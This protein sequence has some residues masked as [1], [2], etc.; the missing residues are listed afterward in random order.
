MLT[1][2]PLQHEQ[3][4]GEPRVPCGSDQGGGKRQDPRIPANCGSA[5]GGSGRRG[6]GKGADSAPRT[7]TALP[8]PRVLFWGD[9]LLGSILPRLPR[10]R[11][12]HELGETRPVGSP[13]FRATRMT[14]NSRCL[15]QVSPFVSRQTFRNPHKGPVRRP[16]LL[17]PQT[18]RVQGDGRGSGEREREVRSSPRAPLR[19][20]PCR[21]RRRRRQGLRSGPPAAPWSWQPGRPGKPLVCSLPRPWPPL[22]RN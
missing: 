18:P 2:C 20:G 22:P 5:A 21:R 8:A 15:L 1:P 10:H 16:G 9:E 6:E 14:K 12:P 19:P 3:T 7:A 13:T 11:F 4:L 17:A